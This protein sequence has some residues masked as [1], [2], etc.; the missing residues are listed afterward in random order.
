MVWRLARM[1]PL[2]LLLDVFQARLS[3]QTRWRDRP[4]PGLGTPEVPLEELEN[5]TGEES[6][7]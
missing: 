5:I 6:V 7:S 4:W 1:P 2:R 3:G